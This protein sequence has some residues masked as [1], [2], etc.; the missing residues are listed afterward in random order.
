MAYRSSGAGYADVAAHYR[1]RIQSGEL[2][3]GDKLPTVPEIQAQFDVS[4]KTVSR[5]L[6][7]LKSEGLVAARGA[8]GT[9]VTERPRVAPATGAARVERVRNGGPN[10]AP[11]ET[12]TGHRA[13][14]R[15]CADPVIAQ[16]LEI[17]P[18]DEIVIRV[19]VFRQNGT[20]KVIGVEYIH[21]R[22]LAVVDDLL[23]QGPR[24]PVH[25][26]V[27]YEESTGQRITSSPEQRAARFASRDELEALEI[28]LPDSDVAIPVL[29]THTVFHDEEGPLE[30][31]EDVHAPG[32]WHEDR[33]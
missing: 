9:V 20:P 17:E 14:L 6:G 29:V 24:G 1:Q 5:A 22:A 25:W 4:S 23:K 19:R 15:S 31:M 10:Y 26:F 7:V 27:Q 18:H 12:S 30:V 3:P 32:Q 28:S 16:R 21:P 2:K 8:L 33:T 13:M 11:G